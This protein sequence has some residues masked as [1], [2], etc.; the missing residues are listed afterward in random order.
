MKNILFAVLS[1][2][3]I[4]AFSCTKDPLWGNN[5]QILVRFHNTLDTRI[6]ASR[7]E[8]DST[9]IMDVGEIPAGETTDYIAF[10]Y[11][12]VGYYPG[13]DYQF[14]TGYFKGNKDGVAFFGWSGNWC[15]TGVEYKQLE[16]GYYTIEIEY[17]NPNPDY[18]A[19]HIRFVE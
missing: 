6:E 16:P 10:D 11:F 1:F 17:L 18:S 7:M 12:Q 13:G 9:N 5:N 15:G 8:F 2:A 3:A 4:L 19:Y 14:P